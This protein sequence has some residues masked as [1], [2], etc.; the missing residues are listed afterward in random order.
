M[1]IKISFPEMVTRMRPL[2]FQILG[3]EQKLETFNVIANKQSILQ[4]LE[5]ER[6]CKLIWKKIVSWYD[7]FRSDRKTTNS[8]LV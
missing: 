6:M 3:F 7:Q 8:N 2:A 4:F 5:D 1:D